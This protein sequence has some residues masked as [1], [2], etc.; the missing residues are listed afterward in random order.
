MRFYELC[1]YVKPEQMPTKDVALTEL[2]NFIDKKCQPWIEA[3]RLADPIY[4]GITGVM[5]ETGAFVQNVRTNRQP[6]DSTPALHDAFNI[7]LNHVGSYANRTNSLFV[8]GSFE[9][10]KEFGK[11]Y[12]V[13]P[14]GKF[15]FTWSPYYDDWTRQF[16]F[17]EIH[18]LLKP[19]AFPKEAMYN[20]QIHRDTLHPKFNEVISNKENFRDD[21]PEGTILVD[22][23]L[24]RAIS[25][26]HEIL[27]RCK[28]A[29][30]IDP[31]V[32]QKL[33]NASI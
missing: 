23:D 24:Q 14:V 21:E 13:M 26:G 8:S 20:V 31:E 2:Y 1:E 33:Q 7:L 5:S 17:S 28:S 22:R 4:R 15:S 27:L 9:A 16:N 19:D 6:K 18:N 30:F 12:I 10:A 29:L 3:T 25:S 32:Y 11:V